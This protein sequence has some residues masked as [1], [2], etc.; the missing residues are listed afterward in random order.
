MQIVVMKKRDPPF[1]T[2]RIK[3]LSRGKDIKNKNWRIDNNR[4]LYNEIT[5]LVVQIAH[6]RNTKWWKHQRTQ[7]QT[8]LFKSTVQH[9]NTERKAQQLKNQYNSVSLA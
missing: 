9:V 7:V 4:R 3:K 5:K 2:P 1:V 8:K 6:S